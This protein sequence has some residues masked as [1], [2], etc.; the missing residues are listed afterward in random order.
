MASSVVSSY[1]F[2]G[3]E[4]RG[5]PPLGRYVTPGDF[6]SNYLR[7]VCLLLLTKVCKI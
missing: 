5:L 4:A 2:G 1:L 6:K 3:K 7:I